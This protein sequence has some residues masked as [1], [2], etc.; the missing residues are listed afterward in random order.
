MEGQ[1][2][3][4]AVSHGKSSLAYYIVPEITDS[5]VHSE[6]NPPATNKYNLCQYLNTEERHELIALGYDTGRQ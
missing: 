2:V 3:H 4:C 6:N 1:W 5:A